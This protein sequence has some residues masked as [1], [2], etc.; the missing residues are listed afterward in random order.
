MLIIFTQAHSTD[1]SRFKVIYQ[2]ERPMWKTVLT[3]VLTMAMAA[4]QKSVSQ[5]V[6]PLQKITVAITSQPEGALLQIAVSNG[7]F[8]DEGLDVQ[9]LPHTFGGLAL[10]SVIENKADFATVAETPIMFSILKGEKIFVLATMVTSSTNNAVLARKS[11]SIKA[12]ADLL[13]KR[14]GFTPGTTS[15][16][17]LD[18]LLI[19]NSLR[20]HDVQLVPL[21][22]EDM[23]D[24][25]MAGQVDAVSTFNY[26]LTQIKQQLGADG[27]AFYDRHLYTETFNV[28]SR[29]DFVR[30][31]VQTVDRFL[32]AL[33]KAEEFAETNQDQAQTIVAAAIKIDKKLVREVWNAFTFHVE[34]NRTL[35]ITLQDE[36]RWAIREKLTQ[37]TEMPDYENF[38]YQ[39]S[40]KSVKP[41][42]V[43]A[44]R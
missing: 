31:N 2:K 8:A 28:T 37:L 32:R 6:A 18:S 44:L 12:P 30:N 36:T 34:L 24:A 16:F 26:P 7:F 25:I 38:I 1:E 42:A 23:P 22:P 19:A 43:K 41:E 27:L 29:Q 3:V 10:Q 15:D 9:L 39:D 20:R 17:F 5:S 14:M 40:L 4:C 35:L 11:A 33:I 21:K 13:G